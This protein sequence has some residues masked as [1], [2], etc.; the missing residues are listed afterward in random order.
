MNAHLRTLLTG[1]V[2]DAGRGVGELELLT[3][4]ERSELAGLAGGVE[5][6]RAAS[7]VVAAI[8]DQVASTPDA[9]A[10]RFGNQSLSYAELDARANR[11]A[12]HLRAS[13]VGPGVLVGVWMERSVEMLVA[14]LATLRSGGALLP[15]DPGFPASA[16]GSWSPTRRRRWW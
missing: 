12:R 2:S 9:A 7:S 5:S 6:G 4:G 11:L 8:R 14:V 3:E 16:S 1:A 13:G 15:L 10:V